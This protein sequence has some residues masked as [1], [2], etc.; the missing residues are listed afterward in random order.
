MNKDQTNRPT[1][2]ISR[3]TGIDRRWIPSSGHHPE[4]RRN[5]DRRSVRDR[6]AAV[7]PELKGVAEN[8]DLFPEIRTGKK[9]REEKNV[10]LPFDRKGFSPLSETMSKR[11]PSDEK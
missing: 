7:L 11:E 3:R 9:N 10:S 4:R 6:S 2:L 5:T 1:A 8:K